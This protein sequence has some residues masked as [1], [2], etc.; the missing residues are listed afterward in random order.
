[1][2]E[3]SITPINNSNDFFAL[4]QSNYFNQYIFED[5]LDFKKKRK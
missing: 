3:E 2:C 5:I 4:S 1:M